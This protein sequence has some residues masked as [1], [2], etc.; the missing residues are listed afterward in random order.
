MAKPKPMVPA[1][2]RPVNLVLRSP[3]S[4]RENPPQDLGYPVNP[5][6]VDEGQGS[7]TC[8]RK[9]VRTTQKPRNWVFSSEA[10]EKCSKIRFLETG[11]QGG[12]F[13]L[14]WY[15][16]TCTGSDSKNRVSQHDVHKPL[17]HDEGLPFFAKEVG[18]NSRVLNIFNG[19]IQDKCVDMVECSCLRQRMQPFI[20]DRIIWR[21]RTFTRTR[22]SRKL[23]VYSISHRNWYWSILQRFW[24]RIRLKVH[25]PHRRD[26][27]CLMVKWSSGQ[28][29]PYVFTQIPYY[30]WGRW[31]TAKMLLQDVQVKWKNSKCPFLTKNCWES[32]ENQ[33]NSS[34]IFS[35]DVRHCRF[36]RKI[37][38]DLRERNIEHEKLTDRIMFMSMFY[39]IDW[40]RKGNDKDS[41]GPGDEKKWY[42]TLPYTP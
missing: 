17:I 20:L 6:N 32:M 13:E 24:M 19:S 31:R 15:K 34:R 16:E 1:K 9:L 4:A 28:K 26:Q 35:Q 18:N 10:T 41:C 40:T 39:D 11:R 29:Q 25:L 38:D 2:A 3:W 7:Q 12:I 22:T 21:T 33:L 14:Y 37:Q 27:T 36:F 5:G 30:A 8:T 42:G 23:R